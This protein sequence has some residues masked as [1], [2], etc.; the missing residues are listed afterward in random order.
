MVSSGVAEV[1]RK[2]SHNIADRAGEQIR[3]RKILDAKDFPDSPDRELVPK[4]PKGIRI[5]EIK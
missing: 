3:V 4:I 1:I 5:L 2:N